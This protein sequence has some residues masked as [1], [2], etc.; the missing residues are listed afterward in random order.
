MNSLEDRITRLEIYIGDYS[1]GPT[2]CDEIKKLEEPFQNQYMKTLLEFCFELDEI[3]KYHTEAFDGIVVES[4]SGLQK[5]RQVMKSLVLDGR[6]ESALKDLKLINDNIDRTE[7]EKVE[8]SVE[9]FGIL[10]LFIEFMR[11]SSE[12]QSYYQSLSREFLY[13]ASKRKDIN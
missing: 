10:E 2:M 7:T 9:T 11:F 1:K 6:L 13:L 12:V 8:F 4:E 3:R 5:Y